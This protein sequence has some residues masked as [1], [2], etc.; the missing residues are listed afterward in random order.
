MNQWIFKKFLTIYVTLIP[1]PTFSLHW[2][3]TSSSITESIITQQ[4]EP[5]W[6]WLYIITTSLVCCAI[7]DFG[8][9]DKHVSLQCSLLFLTVWCHFFFFTV[10]NISI[11]HWWMAYHLLSNSCNSSPVEIKNWRMKICT[12][13]LLNHDN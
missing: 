1:W 6:A 10:E 7:Q 5:Y 11:W 4:L 12:S 2:P 9:S 8:E 3:I 13:H